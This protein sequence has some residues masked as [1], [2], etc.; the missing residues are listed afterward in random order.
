M[1]KPAKRS[2]RTGRNNPQRKN[3]AIVI[4][5]LAVASIIFAVVLDNRSASTTAKPAGPTN[6]PS[7]ATAAAAATST[8]TTNLP[9]MEVKQA[10]MVTV[11]L[12]FGPQVPSIADALL[13]IE[14]RHMPED[15]VGRAFAILDAYGGPTADGRKLHMSMH[16]SLEKTGIGSLVFRRT[17]ET[18]WSHRIIPA[19]DG[20]KSAGPTGLTILFDNGA[21]RTFTVDGS[22]NPSM[23]LQAGLK[24][25][26]IPVDQAWPDGAER[27][28][29]F[30]YSGCG[31]PVKVMCQRVGTRTVRTKEMPVIFPDDPDVVSVIQKLMGW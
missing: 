13:Q 4:A 26:G 23:I 7:S 29:T 31:C 19:S 27:E 16:V 20:T 8:T 25:S 11:E 15:G 1:P 21:G 2:Q 5:G 12:D 22:T 17:G 18:L 30:L 14:R 9:Q 6:L 24:E 10:V 3:W 28:V